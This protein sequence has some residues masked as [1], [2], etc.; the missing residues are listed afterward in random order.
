MLEL[1]VYKLVQVVLVEH[2]LVLMLVIEA[3][4]EVIRSLVLVVLNKGK[5]L[6]VEVEELL[7]ITKMENLVVVEEVHLQL[8]LLQED[9]QLNHPHLDQEQIM[10]TE[11]EIITHLAVV[12]HQLE[13]EVQ[14]DKE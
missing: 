8:P 13:E 6:V 7:M 2:I 4:M 12:G 3:A 5:E 9:H 14:M 11:E 1:M 10:E